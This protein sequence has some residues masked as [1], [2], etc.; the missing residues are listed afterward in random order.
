MKQFNVVKQFKIANNQLNGIS[1][2][3]KFT[4]RKFSCFTTV[5]Q[6]LVAVLSTNLELN[7]FQQEFNRTLSSPA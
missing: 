4:K 5:K 6:F 1:N 3:S 2:V 7:H